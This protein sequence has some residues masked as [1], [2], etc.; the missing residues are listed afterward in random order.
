[1]YARVLFLD[2]LAGTGHSPVWGWVEWGRKVVP[3]RCRL[4]AAAAVCGYAVGAA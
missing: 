1:M 3:G 2:P 4:Q